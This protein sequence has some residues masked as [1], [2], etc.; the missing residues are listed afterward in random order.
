MNEP[1]TKDK[2]L[3]EVIEGVSLNRDGKIISEGKFVIKE[4]HVRVIYVKSAV[5]WLK[6][7][8]QEN[9]TASGFKIRINEAFPDLC[10]SG[11]LIA[12]KQNPQDT[13]KEVDESL[14][15]EIKSLKWT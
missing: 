9:M 2:I 7:N 12:D 4:P 1:L 14:K 10:P 8:I 11:D 13:D 3:N 6:E 15:S 5:E